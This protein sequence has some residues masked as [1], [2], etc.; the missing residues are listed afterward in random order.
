MKYFA[1]CSDDPNLK[2]PEWLDLDNWIIQKTDG[3]NRLYFFF[4]SHQGNDPRSGHRAI[5]GDGLMGVQSSEDNFFN[6]IN[7]KQ[8]GCVDLQQTGRSGYEVDTPLGSF[9]Q[10]NSRSG[11]SP[12][13]PDGGVIF[14]NVSW[15]HVH[16]KNMLLAHVQKGGNILS[17]NYMSFPEST[18]LEFTRNNAGDIMA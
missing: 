5:G 9:A 11:C 4:A 18:S 17:L 1:S 10:I 8:R 14:V 16:N 6:G 7:A 15:T 12:G 13:D 2:R 3:F